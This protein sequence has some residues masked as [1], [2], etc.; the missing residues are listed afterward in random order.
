MVKFKSG[1]CL[2][3]IW[4]MFGLNKLHLG[5]LSSPPVDACYSLSGLAYPFLNISSREMVGNY[6]NKPFLVEKKKLYKW[7]SGKQ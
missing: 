7:T 2:F 5:S 3:G 6:Q 1:L 4:F